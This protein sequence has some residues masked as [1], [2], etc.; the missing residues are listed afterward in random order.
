MGVAG[1]ARPPITDDAVVDIMLSLLERK[2]G[3]T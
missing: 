3:C 1:I 2:H